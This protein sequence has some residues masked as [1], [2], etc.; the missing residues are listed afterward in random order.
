MTRATATLN[1]LI[2]ITRDGLEFYTQAVRQVDNPHLK[3]LFR[4]IVDAK[5]QLIAEL[6]DRIRERSERPA[7]GGTFAGNLHK[8]YADLRVRLSRERKAAY[9][10]ELEE[11]EDRLLAAFEQAAAQT[12]DPGVQRAILQN[13]PKIRL[14]HE[15]MR[16]LKMQLAA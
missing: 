4:G 1:E 13:L 6:S 10:A 9:V 7:Q 16:N 2:E 5:H 12:P 14:C 8:L 15:E 11:S 3:I